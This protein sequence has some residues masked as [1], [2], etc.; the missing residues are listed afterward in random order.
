MATMQLVVILALLPLGTM[1]YLIWQT[2][3]LKQ[4]VLEEY[5]DQDKY[6]DVLGKPPLAPPKVKSKEGMLVKKDEEE[7]AKLKLEE[8]KNKP[9]LQRVKDNLMIV[10]V[11]L[12]E[13]HHI[14]EVMFSTKVCI[15]G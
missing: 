3:R 7:K 15:S 8:E 4:A 13:N 5:A 12:R 1:C 11:E 2:I 10:W 14:L 6:I 9:L